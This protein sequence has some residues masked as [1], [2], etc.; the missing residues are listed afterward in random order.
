MPSLLLAALLAALPAAQPLAGAQYAGSVRAADQ[1][2]PGATITAQSGDRKVT[3]FTDENGQFRMDLTPGEWEIQVEMF[4]FSPMRDKITAGSEPIHKDWTLEMPRLDQ[5]GGAIASNAPAAVTA[6]PGRRGGRGQF[7]NGGGGRGGFG[8]GGRGGPQGAQ[9]AQPGAPQPGFQSAAVRLTQAPPTQN[10]ETGLDVGDIGATGLETGDADEALLVNGSTSGGLAQA[11][12]DESRRQRAQGGRGGNG[13]GGFGFVDA[14]GLGGGALGLPPGMSATSNDSLGL[15]GFGASAINGG[16]GVG[17]GA[18]G[19]GGPGGGGF[20]GPGGGGGGA[21]GRGGGG[22]GGRGGGGRG[23]RGAQNARRGPYNGQFANFGNRRRTAPT[24]TGSVS[25]T[26]QNSA[27]NA[28]PFSLNGIPSQKPYSSSNNFTATV[29]GP[30]VVPKLFNFPRANFNISYRGSY[31]LSGTNNLGTVPT[32]AER[33]GNFSGITNTIYDPA[34]GAPFPDNTIPVSRINPAA[35]GLL[36]YFP[37]PTYQ[38]VVQNYRLITTAPALSQTIGVRISAPINNKDRTTLNVQYQDRNSKSKQLFGYTDDSSGY[39]L[40]AAAGWSHS[41]AP[42]FNNTANVTFSRNVVQATPYFA[43]STN[44]AEA[45]GISDTQNPINYGPPSL[46]F[47]NFSGLSD[48]SASLSRNQTTNFTDTI[49]YVVRR[50]HNLTFGFL[51]RRLDQASLSYANARGSFGFSGLLT[52]ELNATGQP[53]AGTGYDFADFLLGEPQSFALRGSSNDYFRSWSAAWYAQDDWRPLAGLTINVGLRYEYF[54]P[55]TELYGRLANLD[56]NSG[57]TAAAVVTPGMSGPYSGSVPTSL[58]RSMPNNYS[59]RLGV[60]YRPWRKRS[61]II[62]TGYSIFY[63]GSPY[64][65]IASSMASQPPYAPTTA[66]I[67]TGSQYPLTLENAFGFAAAPS[68]T[69]GNPAITNTFAV[70][71][72]YKIANAQTWNFTV[73]NTLPHGWVIETEYIGTKGTN[74]AINEQP[75]RTL[76]GT[77][78]ATQTLQIANTTGFTYLTSGA[79]STFNAGQARITRRFTQGDIFHCSVHVFE[80]DRRRIELQRDRRDSGAVHR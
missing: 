71:P 6:G 46:S 51:Y 69:S 78:V 64:G 72:D 20:G 47:T 49:T 13:G 15:G 66:S 38:D 77:S 52:S 59:P 40:S 16:F 63:S 2:V 14:S 29:G 50:K 27:L 79:N 7:R 25:L 56:L 21:G 65:S 19:G 43:D 48:G 5:R 36:G 3:A 37:Q 44:V 67:T 61:L 60:A 11:S 75:D 33:A 39:G 23:G 24:Y 31:G 17:P 34:N 12:D 45:L 74:L 1:L 57:F 8:A 22:G 53:V 80:I 73:Q 42:R 54:A 28:A 30:L 18:D 4:E 26:E 41:F 32:D 58:V 70:N 55:Y 35:A 9:Q 62:R 10:P 76:T 68:Q